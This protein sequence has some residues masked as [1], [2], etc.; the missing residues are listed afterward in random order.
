MFA[1]KK[2]FDNIGFLLTVSCTRNPTKNKIN[3]TVV[4]SNPAKKS[5]LKRTIMILK[6]PAL[7]I[8][9]AVQIM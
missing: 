5:G 9:I 3:S 8:T 7:K 2:G 1:V 6:R 4:I